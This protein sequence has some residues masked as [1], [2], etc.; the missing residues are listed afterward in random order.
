[1]ER[2]FITSNISSATK[3]TLFSQSIYS[4]NQ[5]SITKRS[6]K[7]STDEVRKDRQMVRTGRMDERKR[8]LAH[9]Y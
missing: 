1:M 3:S 8:V 2:F 4:S 5:T 6:V 7:E 9:Y